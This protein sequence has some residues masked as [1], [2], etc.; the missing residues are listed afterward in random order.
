MADDVT[1]CL[2]GAWTT[3][4]VQGVESQKHGHT[5]ALEQHGCVLVLSRVA[6]AGSAGHGSQRSQFVRRGSRRA[7]AG[8]AARG[9]VAVRHLTQHAAVQGA[10]APSVPRPASD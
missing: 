10:C 4:Q 5:C 9:L 6:A 1:S 3:S 8:E 7:G 2:K